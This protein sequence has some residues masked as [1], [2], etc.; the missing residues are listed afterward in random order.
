MD[1]D[2]Y[3]DTTSGK[4]RTFYITQGFEFVNA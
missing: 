1:T 3:L 2:D 4:N